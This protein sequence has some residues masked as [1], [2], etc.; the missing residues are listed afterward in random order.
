MARFSLKLWMLVVAGLLL[1]IGCG[2]GGSG[3]GGSPNSETRTRLMK[4]L[5]FA[6]IAMLQGGF[7]SLGQ[8][9][10]INGTTGEGT[11]GGSGTTGGGM[12]MPMIGAFIRNFGGGPKPLFASRLVRAQVG[13]TLS[14]DQ[15]VTGPPNE[16]TSGS[17][18]SGGGGVEDPY[19]YYDE[20]LGLWVES[21]WTDNSWTTLLFIDQ[22]KTQ[23]AG[24]FQ[25][26][27]SDWQTY[28]IT[29][30]STYEIIAGPF[31][32]AHGRYEMVFDT[33][34]VGHMDYDNFWPSYGSDEGSSSWNEEGWTWS[35]N[36]TWEDGNWSKSSGTYGS[37]G[38]GHFVWENSEGY[39]W[40]YS[41]F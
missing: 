35:A 8:A 36:Q 3:P 15:F 9:G 26:S 1:V 20:W 25:N 31:A 11:T 4:T 28:P 37:D 10:A 17:T 19:F 30:S 22:E 41:Y 39:K 33:E 13:A 5:G 34:T 2:G 27:Y 7:Q 16:G 18:S 38:T 23:P 24:S 6:Q 12:S 40:S 29:G 21:Q 32:G 14:R